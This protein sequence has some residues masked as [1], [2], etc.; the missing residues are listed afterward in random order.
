MFVSL[1]FIIY[2]R[3]CH[4]LSLAAASEAHSPVAELG[5]LIS[6]SGPRVKISEDKL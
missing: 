5:L 1:D 3:V 4:M 6:E 2:S